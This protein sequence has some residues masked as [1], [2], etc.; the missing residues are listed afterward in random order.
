M[1]TKKYF[2]EHTED[3]QITDK[4]TIIYSEYENNL[5]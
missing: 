3:E 1:L 5:E 4:A 2:I